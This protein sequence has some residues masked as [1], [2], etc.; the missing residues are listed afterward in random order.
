VKLRDANNKYKSLLKLAKERIQGQEEEIEALKQQ[1]SS[2]NKVVQELVSQR[3]DDMKRKSLLN[4]EDDDVAA[5][6]HQ[7]LRVCQRIRV[8]DEE[9]DHDVAE[10]DN[11]KQAQTKTPQSQKENENCIHQEGINGTDRMPS[12]RGGEDSRRYTIWALLQ[13]E[14]QP[15]EDAVIT[16]TANTNINNN[17]IMGQTK[18]RW[19]KWKKFLSESELSD[20]IFRDTGEPIVLPHYS[21]TPEQSYNVEQTSKAAVAQI[22]EEFRR[23]RVRAEVQRKQADATIKALQGATLHTVQQRIEGWHQQQGSIANIMSSD[24]TTITNTT[25]SPNS[26]IQWKKELKEQEAQWREAYDSLLQE[27]NV[28]KS[29]GGE[30][31]LASQWRH[32]YEAAER[33][34]QDY[35]IKVEAMEQQLR[36]ISANN[37]YESKYRDLKESFRLYRKKAKEMFEAQ[38]QQQLHPELLLASPSGVGGGG[39]AFSIGGGDDAKIAYLRN[40]MVNYLSSDASMKD[41]MEVAIKTVLQ[42]T[43]DDIARIEKAKKANEAWF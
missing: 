10:E 37:K 41:P 26:M 15:P 28:L 35:A 38:Q 32:R 29:A 12:E 25:T 34:K 17:V 13:Y 2:T 8:D 5:S 24:T 9:D 43:P 4:N 42:F 19:K 40:L 22:T 27:N 11:N 6:Y 39:G 30:A 14:Y 36:E 18:K 1:L 16:A 7:L 3:S 23:Y 31:L 33:E 20:F 21:L